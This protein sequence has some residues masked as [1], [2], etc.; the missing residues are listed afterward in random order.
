MS[1]IAIDL[2]GLKHLNDTL[3]HA[4]GDDVIRRAGIAI[5]SAIRD[6]DIAAR[7]G[8][9]EFAVLGI[10]CNLE[11]SKSL[12]ERI[13]QVFNEQGIQASIGFTQR[14]PDSGLTR[15]LEEADNAMYVVKRSKRISN[16]KP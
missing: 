1:A 12:V 8:G 4:A 11:Q 16:G 15:A 7:L 5:R 9:D 10:E 13:S 6:H 2:D 14:H 3:G